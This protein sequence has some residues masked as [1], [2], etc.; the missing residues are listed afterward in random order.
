MGGSGPE[1]HGLARFTDDL[2]AEWLY[3]LDAELPHIS[4]CYSLNVSGE[5]AYFCP[6]T[7][8]HILSATGERVT[9][10]GPEYDV[11]TMLRISRDG[12]R[13][14]GGQCRVVLPDGMEARGLRY[15]CRGDELH[16]FIRST[17][18]RTDL[19]RLSAAADHTSA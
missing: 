18:Y 16:A 1:G 15:T 4:D 17:W 13:Q 19:D 5:T 6:Y 10:W 7:T 9:D 12:V 2:T 14:E 3:P 8:F 11:A